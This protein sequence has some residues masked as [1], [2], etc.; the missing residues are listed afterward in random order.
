MVELSSRNGASSGQADAGPPADAPVDMGRIGA[1]LRRDRRLIIAIVVVV[2]GLVL[3]VSLMS[4]VRYSASA[5]IADDPVASGS[6]DS[7][8]ADRQLATNRALVTTPAVLN[9]AAA[10]VPGATADSLSRTVSATVDP[11]ASIL[12]ITV[13]DAGADRAARLAN[14]VARAFL[15]QTAKAQSALLTQAQTRLQ[16][17]LDAQRRRGAKAAT[18]QALRSRFGDIAADGV[19]AGTGLRLVQPATPPTTPASPHPLRSTVFAVFAS[20]LV[21]GLI[22]VARDRLRRRRPDAQAL[23]EKVDVPLL[24]ALPVV[25]R[26]PRRGASKVTDGAMLEE[27]ALQ[28]A[29]RAA[30]PPRGQRVV[31][32]HGM[33][34][35]SHA[36]VV[37]AALARALTWAGHATVL[38]RLDGSAD[39]SPEADRWAP[40]VTLEA[41]QCADLEEGLQEVKASSYRYVIVQS[42]HEAPNAQ[43]RRIAADTGGIVLVARLGTASDDDAMEARRLI[44]ALALEPIGLVITCTATDRTLVTRAGFAATPRRRARARSPVANGS[45]EIAGDKP[46]SNV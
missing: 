12:D 28:A 31:L 39:R 27:A 38:L 1:A 19:V 17:E 9:A 8:T 10:A 15:A 30:L 37:A 3:A 2:S 4:P 11:A 46:A 45:F 7:T 23:S 26:R 43:L 5:R 6:A 20:L 32:V 21:A 25:G 18:L 14:A 34:P 44:D 40:E 35:D 29:V 13:T 42:P 36:P 33:G 22:A 41:R 24:A 16:Q